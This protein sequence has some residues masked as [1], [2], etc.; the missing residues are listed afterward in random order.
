MKHQMSFA[1]LGV[2]LAI[3]AL[4]VQSDNAVAAD[5]SGRVLAPGDLI[6]IKIK[7]F[8]APHQ[9]TTIQEHVATNG[10]VPMPLVGDVQVAGKN[11]ADAGH[12]I[13]QALSKADLVQHAGAKVTLSKAGAK[14]RPLAP[15]DR[16]RI[17][18]WDIEEPG[19]ATVYEAVLAKDGTIPAPRLGQ[20]KLLGLT[21]S[22]AM[23]ALA[24]DYEKAD[25]IKHLAVTVTQLDSATPAPTDKR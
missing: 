3:S 17:Q 1:C 5:E 23:A 16:V 13:D 15:G 12:A 21:E 10:S 2:M 25:L 9:V 24:K 8:L 18:M 4:L 20:A 11:L 6:A 7:D 19:K 22:Q 14:L